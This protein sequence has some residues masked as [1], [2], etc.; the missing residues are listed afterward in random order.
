MPVPRTTVNV[1]LS[2]DKKDGCWWHCD[3]D[4]DV[5]DDTTVG[6][7]LVSAGY[8]TATVL[9][10]VIIIVVVVYVYQSV[11]VLT[12][13]SS[14]KINVLSSKP[15]QAMTDGKTESLLPFW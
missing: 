8:I 14:S 15:C 4:I 2:I 9:V 6:L 13:S 7:Q 3:I 5:L 1:T 12:L 10:V 11:C